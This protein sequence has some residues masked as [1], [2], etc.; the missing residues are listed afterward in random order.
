MCFVDWSEYISERLEAVHEV[1]YV[2]TFQL[3]Q[4]NLI[5]DSVNIMQYIQCLWTG[6][7]MSAVVGDVACK[8]YDNAAR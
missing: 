1:Q 7:Y 6:R 8:L 2:Y 4:V 5:Q 3:S